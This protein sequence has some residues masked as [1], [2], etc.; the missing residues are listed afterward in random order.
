VSDACKSGDK[1]RLRSGGGPVMTVKDKSAR[2]RWV[3]TWFVG[4]K[5]KVGEFRE[6][7]LEL[8]RSTLAPAVTAREQL[9]P[10]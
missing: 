2:E 4:N 1:V 8:L 10:V 3:C 7:E 6:A 9:P 5:L